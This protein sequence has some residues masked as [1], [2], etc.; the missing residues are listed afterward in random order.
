MSFTTST[1]ETN[2]NQVAF[3]VLQPIAI[4]TAEVVVLGKK[5]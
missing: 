4:A 2:L 5:K 1:D 3:F